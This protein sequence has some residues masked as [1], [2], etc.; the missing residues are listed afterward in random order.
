MARLASSMI[1]PAASTRREDK[2]ISSVRLTNSAAGLSGG[3]EIWKAGKPA[4]REM[5]LDRAVR[6]AISGT[7]LTATG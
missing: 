1:G 2:T 3:S 6:A 4:S 7:I 5:P